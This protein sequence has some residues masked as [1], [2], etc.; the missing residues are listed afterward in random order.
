MFQLVIQYRIS[1]FCCLNS[2]RLGDVDSLMA[3]HLQG[4][5]NS[6]ILS[7]AHTTMRQLLD[8]FRLSSEA[9]LHYEIKSSVRH[10]LRHAHRTEARNLIHPRFLRTE[11]EILLRIIVSHSTQLH[12]LAVI[13]IHL[14]VLNIILSIVLNLIYFLNH[15]LN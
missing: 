13:I 12:M 4:K 5:L 11:E 10:L 6:T 8:Q 15:N 3:E 1:P 2:Q 7:L 14:L 9:V